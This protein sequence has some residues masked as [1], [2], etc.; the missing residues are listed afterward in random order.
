MPG[1]KSRNEA[2]RN[3]GRNG[4]TVLLFSSGVRLRI[5]VYTQSQGNVPLDVRIVIMCG[6]VD[7][8]INS[9]V[10]RDLGLETGDLS[11]GEI[12]PARVARVVHEVLDSWKRNGMSYK[13]LR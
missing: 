8:Q 10:G 6:R 3:I 4:V 2:R 13:V 5:R 12:V 11:R 1:E 7:S 9:T